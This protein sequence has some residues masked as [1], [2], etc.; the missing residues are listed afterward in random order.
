MSRISKPFSLSSQ[1]VPSIRVLIFQ[2]ALVPGDAFGDDSCVRISYAESLSVLQAAVER[3]KEA[4]GAAR[5]VVP[6]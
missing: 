6:A 5:P 1:E 4:L 3:I 2:V